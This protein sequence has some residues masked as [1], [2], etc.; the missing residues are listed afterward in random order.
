VGPDQGKGTDRVRSQLGAVVGE[1]GAG[2]ARKQ[3]SAHHV[4]SATIPFRVKRQGKPK[5][6][7]SRGDLQ[8][9]GIGGAFALCIR[10]Q[11]N[12]SPKSH[13]PG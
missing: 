7:S 2:A 1:L 13:G 9:L 5:T 11:A 10:P 3:S 8:C 6:A 4:Q 12:P